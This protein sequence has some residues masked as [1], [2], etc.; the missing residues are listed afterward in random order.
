[1]DSLC[2]ER[3]D[4]PER[5]R[6]LVATQYI[7]KGDVIFFERPLLSLQSLG[8]AHQGALVCRCCRCFVGGPD[9]ALQVASRNLKR[10]DVWDFYN[11]NE[12][13]L[14][15]DNENYKMVQCRNKCGELYCS[16]E[17]EEN[18]WNCC[19]HDLLCTGF[20]PEQ[21]DEEV[22]HPLL[23]FKVHA[24]Q[25]NEIFLMVADLVAAAVSLHRQNIANQMVNTDIH[26]TSSSF[27]EEFM[28]PYLDFTLEPWWKVVTGPM[29]DDPMKMAECVSINKTM[30]ELCKISSEL[31][32]KGIL[33]IERSNELF[34]RSLLQ[35]VQDCNEKIGMFSEEFFGK[36]IGSFEQNAMGIRARHPLC[37]D[38]LEDRELRRRRHEQLVKC[39]EIAGM[40]GGNCCDDEGEDHNDIDTDTK[41]LTEEEEIENDYS[42]DEID[43]YIATLE[44]DEEGKINTIRE[45]NE[46]E[47]DEEDSAE[48]DDLDSL[49]CPLDGT[50]MYHIVCKMNHSCDPNVIAKYVYSCS[51]GGNRARWGKLYPLLIQCCAIRD[52][53]EGEEL[54][55]S[56][57]K[58][59][60][61]YEERKVS[62]QNYGFE[63]TCRKC[64]T[65]RSGEVYGAHSSLDRSL[66][67]ND[68]DSFYDEEED[69]REDGD[70]YY[71][72]DP[73]FGYH[74]L[75]RRVKLFDEKLP[76]FSIFSTDLFETTVA[77]LTELGTDVLL[78]IKNE[79]NSNS[80]MISNCLESAIRALPHRYSNEILSSS[81]DGEA[82]SYKL[83]EGGIWQIESV[84]KAHG[85]LALISAIGYAEN[86][87]IIAAMKLIDKSILSGL[88]SNDIQSLHSLIRTHCQNCESLY[89][90]KFRRRNMNVS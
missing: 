15:K 68:D 26:Q 66:I 56:Y 54:C 12:E 34:K 74:S 83:F 14:T 40:I 63:C 76:S 86:G 4:S 28:E 79:R 35:A 46:L 49:F 84:R 41:S 58:S 75:L 90:V 43:A 44:I 13:D 85:I 6:H 25:N 50:S 48:G 3:R 9:L 39:I 21:Y 67:Q 24:C 1:M 19:G 87:N 82:F 5:G 37:R 55:I 31:L 16:S 59:D 8:N 73:S 23:Q 70:S 29:L 27:L 51:G 65:E 89:C 57:I 22:L 69:D 62:L 53:Q 71:D 78:R 77:G 38:I 61:P 36:I 2:Y 80:S 7:H 52:I 88:S 64:V 42:P 33:S 20:I 81:L 72:N 30:R 10:E 11:Q 47:V 32:M 45:D 60:A 17:C 18:M